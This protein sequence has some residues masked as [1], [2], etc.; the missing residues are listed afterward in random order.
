V[1]SDIEGHLNPGHPYRSSDRVGWVHEGTHGVNS[2]LRNTYKKPGFYVL[3]DRAV[4]LDEPNITLTD[5]ANAVPKSL[6][7]RGYALYLVRMAGSWNRQP[8]YVFDE[9]TAYTNG[10][11]ARY[12]RGIQERS[13][14]IESMMDFSV[15]AICV[16]MVARSIDP[17]MRAFLM[18]HFE[19]A[20]SLY[21][22]SG[23]R[24]AES[25]TRLRTE[26]DAESLRQF[27]RHYF[28]SQWTQQVLGF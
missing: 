22:A 14:T 2:Q 25:L 19:R 12:R 26:A 18:W 23:D 5:V 28:G 1:V 11:E 13:D 4:L 8:T 17:Q 24:P 20:L 6:R 27:A 9:W 15:Y 10:T 16:P 21:Y 3:E 7:G